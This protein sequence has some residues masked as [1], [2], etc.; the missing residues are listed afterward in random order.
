M[1]D[2]DRHRCHGVDG[3]DGVDGDGESQAPSPPSEASLSHGI[4]A[5]MGALGG[6]ICP[7]RRLWRAVLDRLILDALGL[8]ELPQ[9]RGDPHGQT[10][11][12]ARGW[13]R[14]SDGD[15]DNVCA[16]A[17]IE[18]HWLRQGMCRAIDRLEELEAGGAR[19]R[20]KRAAAEVIADLTA[21]LTEEIAHAVAHVLPD[22]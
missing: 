3:V 11:R 13:F 5:A 8:T 22:R 17:G 21:D 15:L 2:V 16:F 20:A 1:A 10:V 7:E 6:A 12:Q 18:G 14:G 4:F 19:Y 9:G